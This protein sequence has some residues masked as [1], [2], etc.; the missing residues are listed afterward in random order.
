MPLYT[1]KSSRVTAFPKSAAA[2]I[3]SLNPMKS[4][5]RERT[6]FLRDKS[7]V[8]A[9]E[10]ALIAPIM[11]AIYFGLAEVASA[12]SVDRRVSHTANVVGDLATQTTE[13]TNDDVSEIFAAAVRVLDLNDISSV[14]IEITSYELDSND[15]PVLLG[16]ATL[17]PGQS[18]PP[19]DP[20]TVDNRILN[21]TSGVVVARIAYSYS[22][23][24]LRYT[25]SDINLTELFLLKP[26]RSSSI[27][28]GNDPNTPVVCNAA[29]VSTITC[30]GQ[31]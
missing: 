25:D 11:I 6:A 21:N 5:N 10:F 13:V 12:I 30:S 1:S 20:G 31:T 28:I 24:M 2:K 16:M 8:A 22:P 19:F 9:I 29:S 17:N 15:M 23:L 18:L 4:F 26:R 3:A 14:T 7:G 27:Q